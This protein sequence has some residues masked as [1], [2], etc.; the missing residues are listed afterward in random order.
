[1]TRE[2]REIQTLHSLAGIC[3]KP[4]F[5]RRS[6]LSIKTAPMPCKHLDQ[7]LLK[8]LRLVSPT[9]NSVGGSVFCVFEKPAIVNIS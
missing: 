1:M 7:Y 3:P 9:K 5:S 2:G 8:E 4:S 6:A